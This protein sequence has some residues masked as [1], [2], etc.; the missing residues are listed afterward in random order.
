MS[1]CTL[2][3]MK[4]GRSLLPHGSIY[5][6]GRGE[7]G[8]TEQDLLSFFVS[9]YI[10]RNSSGVVATTMYTYVTDLFFTRKKGQQTKNC[11]SAF[12][13]A[14]VLSGPAAKT[15]AGWRRGNFE[16]GFF[17]PILFSTGNMHQHRS[18]V[19]ERKRMRI[20]TKFSHAFGV[21]RE[22]GARGRRFTDGFTKIPRPSHDLSK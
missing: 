13:W 12:A 2:N 19:Q 6:A 7:G 11:C 15:G 16:N 5:R 14:K 8:G 18:R 20:R 10:P 21:G 9:L 1:V 22:G 3:A 4:D 17:V